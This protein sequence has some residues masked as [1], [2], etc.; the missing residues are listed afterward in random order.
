MQEHRTA[1]HAFIFEDDRSYILGRL[2]V[3]YLFAKSPLLKHEETNSTADLL[4]FPLLATD[5]TFSTSVVAAHSDVDPPTKVKMEEL[6]G[7]WR[8]G[9]QDGGELFKPIPNAPPGT[10]PPQRIIE[11]ALFGRP[12]PPAP[13]A[14]P[15]PIHPHIAPYQNGGQAF[16]QQSPPPS[17][18]PA[19]GQW[20]QPRPPTPPKQHQPPLSDP[21]NVEKAEVLFDIRKMLELR[22]SQ[23]VANPSNRGN[24]DQI[25]TLKQVGLAIYSA[26]REASTCMC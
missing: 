3:R 17:N 13:V 9:G 7:T 2:P 21:L 10:L 4:L 24:L 5:Q 15:A 19:V 25:N 6:L 26:L 8:T 22:R 11:D 1:I 23:L 20:Q 16:H 12:A 14:A 18:S